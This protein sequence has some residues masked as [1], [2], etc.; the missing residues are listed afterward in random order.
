MTPGQWTTWSDCSAQCGVGNRFR[1]LRTCDSIAQSIQC[2][3]RTEQESC[4]TQDCEPEPE[5][6][7]M[8]MFLQFTVLTVKH[9]ICIYLN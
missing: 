1:T 8:V 9:R 6:K 2:T 4:N 3:N 7:G 5:L